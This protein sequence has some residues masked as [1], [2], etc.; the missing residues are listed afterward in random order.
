MLQLGAMEIGVTKDERSNHTKAA[1]RLRGA[2]FNAMAK[3]PSLGVAD[4]A[5]AAAAARTAGS[6][7]DD[8]VELGRSPRRTTSW[9]NSPAL[10]HYVPEVGLIRPPALAPMEALEPESTM[11]SPRDELRQRL[12]AVDTSEIAPMHA[13]S[14][15]AFQKEA[16]F[17]S[18]DYNL[19]ESNLQILAQRAVQ[20][21]QKASKRR[22]I[23][24]MRWILTIVSGI[25]TGTVASFI[26][27]GVKNLNTLKY[28]L[29]MTQI[30]HALKNP[31]DL[32]AHF[33]KPCLVFVALNVSYVLVATLL[34]SFVEPVS[35]GSGIPEVKCYLNGVSVPRVVRFKTLACKAVGVLFS[36]AG[37]LPVGKEGPMIH[38]GAVVG[39]GV[40]Q[41]R[42][43]QQ[44]GSIMGFDPAWIADM[45]N[46]FRNDHEKRDFV[47]C[48]TAAG[49][50]A[51]FGAPIGGALFALEEGATHWNDFLTWRSFVCAMVSGFTL[52]VWMSVLM[53]DESEQCCV[54]ARWLVS[55][56][57]STRN[58]PCLIVRV[59]C[60]FLQQKLGIS[61]SAARSHS[62]RSLARML[63]TQP[64]KFHSSFC[65]GCLVVLSVRCSTS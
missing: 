11:L 28:D 63:R 31:D 59:V 57:S 23:T 15:E 53:K 3:K 54:L 6:E 20:T 34:V 18:L 62:E 47:A 41:G 50:A 27:F 25:A 8:S 60:T 48:G 16:A 49:V 61:I 2:A 13:R 5:K 65:L 40:S 51:A 37:G 39:A 1:D 14:P 26:N 58:P 46:A 45:F 32:A 17:E 44:L 35:R 22:S 33:V 4:V 29:T 9:S 38:S 19:V 55:L 52:D 21:K 64:R 56:C 24:L 36:V 10:Q 12:L 43:V 30:G 7:L 42:Q